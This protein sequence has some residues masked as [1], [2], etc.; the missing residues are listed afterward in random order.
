MKHTYLCILVCVVASHVVFPQANRT[1]RVKAGEDVAQAYSPYGFYRFP[2]FSKA[3]LYFN[4]NPRKSDILF[5]YNVLSGTVQFINLKGDTL[6][7][8]NTPGPD[9]ISFGNNVF[10]YNNGFLEVVAQNDSLR[11]LKKLILKT[12]AENIGA[13]GQPNPTGAI[14]NVKDISIGAVVYTIVV[15]QGIVLTVDVNL[16]MMQA[17]DEAV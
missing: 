11:L 3:T 14:T 12:Q 2:Q 15:N 10:L 5:N 17:T 6:D 8:V 7:L 1:I 9:S 16:F 4:G 13:Y